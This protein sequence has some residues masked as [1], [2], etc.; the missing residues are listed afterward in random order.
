MNGDG[1]GRR[2]FAGTAATALVVLVTS[3]WT[4]WGTGELYYEAWGLP[5]PEPLFY[6]VP[7]ACCL[8]LSIVA[9]RWPTA[10]GAIVIAAGGG[11]SA[12]WWGMQT[13]R[14]GFSW[15][16]LLVT[17]PVSGLL[18]LVGVLFVLEG[19]RVRRG[20]G[21][22]DGRVRNRIRRT[23]RRRLAV[24]WIVPCGVFAMVSALELPRVLTRLDDGDR[25]ARRITC[26]AVDL[27][28]APAGPGW[29]PRRPGGWY[30]S[31]E[32]LSL[33]GLAPRGFDVAAKSPPDG[34]SAGAAGRR[35][36]RWELCR[37]L[38]EDGTRLM[39]HP[40]GVWRMPTA[41]E[42]AGSLVRHGRCAD[43]TWDG[44]VPG[45]ARCVE[46]PDKETPLWAPDE[47]PIYYWAAETL[48]P[49]GR[50]ALYVSYR[51]RIGSQPADWANP[52]HGFRCVREGNATTFRSGRG[53]R[54]EPVDRD[55]AAANAQDRSP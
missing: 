30:P 39:D 4:L 22:A 53:Q 33:W 9:I 47:P 40:V 27:V 50:R 49:G 20:L 34:P 54:V 51:G 31:R 55:P 42:I 37:Y 7:A 26:G 1:E 8:V 43:C 5:L 36:G 29:N 18:V 23:T 45:R 25:G 13:L 14:F 12:W 17:M 46:P 19:R 2:G 16:G 48:D 44:R 32:Q 21:G 35:D 11:F 3:L 24:A 15:R 28:W 6:F 52:R 10:G 41:A 38:S